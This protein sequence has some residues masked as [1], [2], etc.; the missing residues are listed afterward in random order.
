MTNLSLRKRF[1]FFTAGLLVL[2][3][4]AAL[5][6]VGSPDDREQVPDGIT[7]SEAPRSEISALAQDA[8][9]A[10]V[11]PSAIPQTS[12]AATR[13]VVPRLKIDAPTITLGVDAKGAMQ[14]PAGPTDVAWYRFSS[15][16]NGGGNVVMS[17]HVDFANHGPA[18]F[19]RLK[20]IETGDVVQVL[21]EDDT[22][23]TYKVTT[24][25][26]YQ[27]VGA[28]VQEIIGRTPTEVITLITCEGVF[29]S[30]TRQYDKRLVV[31][32]VRTS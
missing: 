5:V 32:A 12:R 15:Q 31:R 24:I 23:A 6:F 26:H 8:P 17:G 21:L 22:V 27:A 14:T 3:G 16:P 4:V 19:A 7:I 28:P 13:L 10:A 29:N 25:A 30:L 2:F 1:C 11:V 18:V 20:E 9:P